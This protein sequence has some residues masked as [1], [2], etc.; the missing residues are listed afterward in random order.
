LFNLANSILEECQEA[1]SL[2]DLDTAI[3]MFEE[4]LNLRPAPHPLRSESLKDLVRALL[5]RFSLTNETR[6][7]GQAVML[8]YNIVEAD[9]HDVSTEARGFPPNVRVR[10]APILD[11]K[12]RNPKNNSYSSHNS[13]CT[14]GWDDYKATEMSSLSRV[15]LAK[16]NQSPQLSSLE[17]AVTLHR[18]VLRNRPKGHHKHLAALRGLAAGLYTRFRYT[19][20]IGNIHEAISLLCMAV[21][22]CH[23]PD[24]SRS[25]LFSYLSAM[26][27]TRF[28]KTGNLLDLFEAKERCRSILAADDL[29]GA[30]EAIQLLQSASNLFEQFEQLGQVTDLE[31]SILL[32]RNGIALT[33][34]HNSNR[35]PAYNN[36]SNA[37]MA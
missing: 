23:E 9:W 8:C 37:L 14:V 25:Y 12:L 24:V 35:P 13:V 7:L 5:T 22:F 28:S 29:N 30:G 34:V 11:L 10:S 21:E 31:T 33:P 18:E 27:A 3:F 17:T 20:D 19:D 26:L 1:A 4:V 36:L 32:F 2:S 15:T 16:F 6:D